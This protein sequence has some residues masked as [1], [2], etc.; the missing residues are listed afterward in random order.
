MLNTFS[1]RM[2]LLA[3]V[4]MLGGAALLY[5]EA[6]ETLAYVLLV[7]GF[8]AVGIGILLGFFSLIRSDDKR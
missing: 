8:F 6:A 5:F 7:G 3:I 1:Y 4:A 2:I